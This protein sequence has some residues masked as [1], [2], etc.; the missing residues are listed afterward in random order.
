[1][2]MMKI[3]SLHGEAQDNDEET[4]PD[5]I[6]PYTGSDNLILFI[7]TIS[8]NI[9]LTKDNDITK[10][11]EP[12]NKE[13]TPDEAEACRHGPAGLQY[14]SIHLLVRA[15]AVLLTVIHT[16]WLRLNA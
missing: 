7:G 10:P 3:T 9:H 12:I 4:R 8:N 6:S 13:P 11:Q 15:E 5:E 2:K 14:M 1:M 16:Q